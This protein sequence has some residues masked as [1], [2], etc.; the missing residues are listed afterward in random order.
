MLDRELVQEVLGAARRRGGSFAELFVEEK[1]S[2]SIRLDDGKVEELTTG[3]D[4]GAGVRVCLGTSYGYAYSN[5]LDR[6]ALL[7]AADA[8]SAALRPDGPGEVVDLREPGQGAPSLVNPV[9][10][11]AEELPAAQKVMWLR[12]LDDAARSFS[13]EVSQVVGVYGDSLQR[14]LIATSDGRWVEESR[15]RI[16]LVAQVVASRDGNIQTGFH[17]PAACAG[18]EFVDRHPPGAT[19]EVAAKRAVTMLD[20]IPAPAGETTVVLAPGMG[21]VLFHEAVGHPLES[22]AID[23]E[24]SVYRGLIGERCAS[25]LID[26]VDDATIVNGWGSYAFDDEATPSQR[27]VLFARGVLQGLLYDRM[28]A[29]KDGRPPTGNGR[30]QSYASPPI[31]RMTNTNILNGTSSVADVIASTK[32]GVYVTA[33]GGGQTN[34]ATGDFVFGVAEGFLIE[35]GVVTTPVRGA[36][37]IGRAI[38]VMRGVDALGDDFDT[39]EGVCGK[40]GQ[41]APVGSGSPTLRIG[42][43]TV[44]GTGGSG[45]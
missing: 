21:G 31:P 17:G 29:E 13:P 34:P 25:E 36:N 7:A 19:A 41:A 42:R 35:G 8:A 11:P 38:E 23:K 40:D 15:P 2:T 37:L 12:E 3:L 9:E 43:I 44:G 6:E 24:A 5:R 1:S 14:V 27:T 18:V 45:A 10:R 30:R 4:R 39:W 26:G 28:H 16:R 22:D 32:R 20:S 33:L